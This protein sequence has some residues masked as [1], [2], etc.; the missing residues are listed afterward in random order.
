MHQDK[1]QVHSLQARSQRVEEL[2]KHDGDTADYVLHFQFFFHKLKVC[3]RNLINEVTLTKTQI[4]YK[5]F[6]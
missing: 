5:V 4:L 1:Q 3:K 2:M 6:L